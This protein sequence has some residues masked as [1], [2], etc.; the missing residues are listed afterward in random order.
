VGAELC[1][2]MEANVC[3]YFWAKELV[4]LCNKNQVDS[5]PIFWDANKSENKVI[6]RHFVI[7]VLS[8]LCPKLLSNSKKKQFSNMKG[9]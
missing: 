4:F 6:W 1:G 3:L 9:A 7:R 5:K 2:D 8:G